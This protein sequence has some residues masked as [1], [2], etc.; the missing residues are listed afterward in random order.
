MRWSLLV[1]VVVGLGFG[2]GA[3]ALA[4]KGGKAPPALQGVVVD[5]NGKTIGPYL[6]ANGWPIVITT[7]NG[8]TVSIVLHTFRVPS[9]PPSDSTKLAPSGSGSLYFAS[10]QCAGQAYFPDQLTVLGTRSALTV[11]DGFGDGI[12]YIGWLSGE[13]ILARV[14]ST[15]DAYGNCQ[16]LL[17]ERPLIPVVE[18]VQLAPLFTAP[19]TIR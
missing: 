12:L 17:Q 4:Q 1:A 18:A 6:L 9:E 7:V 15:R 10:A 3:D 16:D 13:T 5:A 14:E 19:Y 11:A 2:I 8:S